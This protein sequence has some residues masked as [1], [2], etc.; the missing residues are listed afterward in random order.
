MAG[1]FGNLSPAVPGKLDK[2]RAVIVGSGEDPKLE[3]R[4]GWLWSPT[5]GKVGRGRG[6]SSQGVRCG[7]L[8]LVTLCLL[9]GSVGVFES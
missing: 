2:A 9:L 5:A 8:L 1:N 6:S 7:H 3:R 4:G